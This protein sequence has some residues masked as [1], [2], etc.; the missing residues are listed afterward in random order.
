MI[1]SAFMLKFVLSLNNQIFVNKR[2]SM[3]FK[4]VSMLTVLAAFA[5]LETAAFSFVM[6]VRLS[7]NN[8]S[9]SS[10]WIFYGS[11]FQRVLYM[12]TCLHL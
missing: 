11:I 7:A 5:K 10:G 6:S 1:Y 3:C 12:K 4:I 2:R 9:S 8:N